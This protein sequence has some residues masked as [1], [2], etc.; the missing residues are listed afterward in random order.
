MGL[1]PIPVWY[2]RLHKREKQ[3]GMRKCVFMRGSAVIVSKGPPAGEPAWEPV[4]FHSL[5]TL[6]SCLVSSLPGGPQAGWGP[7]D[8]HPPRGAFSEICCWV[9][10]GRCCRLIKN[11]E[12]RKSSGFCLVACTPCFPAAAEEGLPSCITSPCAPLLPI[13]GLTS[14]MEPLMDLPAHAVVAAMSLLLT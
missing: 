13:L 3:M 7:T 9:E 2:K 6:H 12:L 1:T 4:D 14:T 10:R 5:L 11:N 8:S